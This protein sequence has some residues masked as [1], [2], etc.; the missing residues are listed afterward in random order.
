MA[1]GIARHFLAVPLR[2]VD[3]VVEM[4]VGNARPGMQ[5][6]L[7]R[8]I[9]GPVQLYL[10]PPSTARQALDRT[11]RALADVDRMVKAFEAAGRSPAGQAL[12]AGWTSP[13]GRTPPIAKVV[14]MLVTEALP[15][16]G[17]RLLHLEPT[18]GTMRV[19]FRIDGALHDVLALPISMAGALVSRVKILANMNIV[20]RRRAL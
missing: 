11:Y 9:G 4:A 14:T 6:E 7:E 15:R 17:L 10:V 20:E 1:E 18:E 12:P 19:R 8:A 2:D 13:S 16:T 5:A 3:G